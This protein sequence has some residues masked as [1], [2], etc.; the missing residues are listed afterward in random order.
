MMVLGQLDS[1]GGA[2]RTVDTVF[3]IKPSMCVEAA[4]ACYTCFALLKILFHHM[5]D[6][7][8]VVC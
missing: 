6:V 4:M 7:Q 1:I 8:L 5:K 2:R 3:A